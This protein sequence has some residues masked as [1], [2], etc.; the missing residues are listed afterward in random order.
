MSL[1]H[2]E[3]GLVVD[4]SGTVAARVETTD[5]VEEEEERQ[6]SEAER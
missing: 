4:R 3:R 6:G 1:Q 2:D 5:V